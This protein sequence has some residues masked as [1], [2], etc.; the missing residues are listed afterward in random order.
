[1]I[2]SLLIA[3]LVVAASQQSGS[4]SGVIVDTARFPVPGATLVVTS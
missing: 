3:A 4:I 1:M 2:A